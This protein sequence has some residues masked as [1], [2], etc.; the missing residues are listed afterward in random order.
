MKILPIIFLIL[1]AFVTAQEAPSPESTE[2]NVP[3]QYKMTVPSAQYKIALRSV[4]YDACL[5]Q[6]IVLVLVYEDG[7]GMQIPIERETEKIW[8]TVPNARELDTAYFVLTPPFATDETMAEV[9][10]C[11]YAGFITFVTQAGAK[12]IYSEDSPRYLTL[13]EGEADFRLSVEL[14]ETAKEFI[15]RLED[16]RN[17]DC[18]KLKNI[19]I[20]VAEKRFE[21]HI[22]E[23]PTALGAKGKAL[24]IEPD[25][26]EEGWLIETQALPENPMDPVWIVEV[27]LDQRRVEFLKNFAEALSQWS[28]QER[29]HFLRKC[30]CNPALTAKLIK[31]LKRFNAYTIDDFIKNH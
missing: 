28:A 8:V 13:G 5:Q 21:A 2:Q 18:T 17:P 6:I 14:S 19:Q 29:S 22:Q 12:Q 4:Y 10:F 23:Q 3:L 20:S 24:M 1:A 27:K 16:N 11:T 15:F 26:R 31:D 9:L 30:R 7:I 25:A